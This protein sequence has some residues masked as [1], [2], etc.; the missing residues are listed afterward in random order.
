MSLNVIT[1]HHFDKLI[2]DFIERNLFSSEHSQCHRI[3]LRLTDF[4]VNYRIKVVTVMA[5]VK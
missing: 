1:N 2:R 3:E 5:I 4:E